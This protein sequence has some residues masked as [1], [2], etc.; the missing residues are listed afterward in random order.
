MLNILMV[1]S[2]THYYVTLYKIILAYYYMGILLHYTTMSL[3]T[4]SMTSI[5][6][7][8]ATIM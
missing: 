6:N 3:L 5:I 1:I 2:P 4:Y 8:F 7:R